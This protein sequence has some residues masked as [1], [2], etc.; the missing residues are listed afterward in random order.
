MVFQAQEVDLRSLKTSNGLTPLHLA[1]MN[2]NEKA[3]ASLLSLG[4]D[5][6]AQD[7]NGTLISQYLYLYLG[8]SLTLFLGTSVLHMALSF[9][10]VQ[11]FEKV[12]SAGA[13]VTVVDHSRMTVF[14]CAALSIPRISVDVLNPHP[15]PRLSSL[16]PL[17]LVSP[18]HLWQRAPT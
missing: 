8:S 18:S 14:H 15:L 7:D 5:P 17:G 3:V 4:L 12:A 16:S 9:G 6:N 1:C 13:S 2:R 10:A 11:C